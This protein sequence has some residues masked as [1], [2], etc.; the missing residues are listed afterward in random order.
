MAQPGGDECPAEMVASPLMVAPSCVE[1]NPRKG[2]CGLTKNFARPATGGSNV[3]ASGD[4][5]STMFSA[6]TGNLI[7]RASS[8]VRPLLS[9]D[10]SHVE[11]GA[12][13]GDSAR[14]TSQDANAFRN[15][16][17]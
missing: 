8:V 13:N 2:D 6:E 5:A 14:A 10:S 12:V 15:I 11:K 9:V 4:D 3:W 1:R 17:D 16:V 7:M